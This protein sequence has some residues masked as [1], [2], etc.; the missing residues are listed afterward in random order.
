[1]LTSW[2]NS[3]NISTVKKFHTKGKSKW[4][5][6]LHLTQDFLTQ[7]KTYACQKLLPITKRPKDVVYPL[8]PDLASQVTHKMQIIDIIQSNLGGGI[9]EIQAGPHWQGVPIPS[10]SLKLINWEWIYL[11]L[12]NYKHDNQFHNL[13]FDI[14]VL[15]QILDPDKGLYQLFVTETSVVD[16]QNL[17]DLE[18]LEGLVLTILR[19]YI[20]KFY[21]LAQ[22]QV[23]TDNMTLDTLG[24]DDPNLNFGKWKISFRNEDAEL[25]QQVREYSEQMKRIAESGSIDSPSVAPF[26]AVDIENHLY[27]PLLVMDTKKRLLQ[28]TPPA[29]V[30]SEQDFVKDLRKYLDKHHGTLLASKQVFLLRNQSR[31]KGI[32][33]YQNEGFY[34]DFILWDSWWSE[35]THC[36]HWTPRNGT[37]SYQ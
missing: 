8:K 11:Q 32:G 21:R 9:Q 23:N 20:A 26:L 24:K 7:T 29:L 17:V 35:T 6:P 19:K 25:I 12:L 10:K 16:P 37:W 15:K 3:E 33:F 31:G 13:I 14:D 2:K 5:Y 34:P 27:Q 28:I 4:S 22:Q 18:R 30:K 1:M 36:F